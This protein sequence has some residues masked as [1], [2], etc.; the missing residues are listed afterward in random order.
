LTFRLTRRNNLPNNKLRDNSPEP[1]K[2]SQKDNE[3]DKD[4]KA[5]RWMG[6]GIEFVGVLAIFAYAGW[7]ADEKLNHDWPWLMLIGF[8]IGFT[9]MIYLLYKE[10][11][12][13]RK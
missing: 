2:K 11:S 8:G 1:G 3:T 13:L 6:F 10:T 12:G 7:W 5:M 4:R 9:G